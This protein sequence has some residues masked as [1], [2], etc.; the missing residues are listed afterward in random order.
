[1]SVCKLFKPKIYSYSVVTPLFLIDT[2]LDIFAFST[3]S[4]N[5]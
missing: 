4:I 3:I 5:S 1:M 2:K